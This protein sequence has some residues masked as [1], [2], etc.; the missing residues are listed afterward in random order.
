MSWY[1]LIPWPIA[2]LLGLLLLAL[3][4]W[5]LVADPPRRW[6]W[7]LRL[8]TALAMTI[9]LLG[10]AISGGSAREDATKVNVFFL[11]DTTTS[12]MARDHDGQRTRLEGY[13]E[14]IAKIRDE[15][16]GAR[17][18][19]ITF[20][21]AARVTM[22]LTTDLNALTS[23]TEGLRA[24]DHHYSGGSSVTLAGERLALALAGAKERTPER[25]RIVFYLGDGEQTASQEPAPF[26][27]GDLVDGGAV[28]GYGS[29]EGG[30]MTATRADGSP[31][32]EVEDAQ[33][34]PGM[35][36]IDEERLRGIAQQIGVPYIHRAGGDIAPALTAAE[37]GTLEDG[38]GA[39]IETHTSLVWILALLMSALLCVDLFVTTRD[40][41]RLS[42]KNA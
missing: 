19:I 22:P 15:M 6:R 12:A 14:D 21:Y 40:A 24:E 2:V 37:P 29:P 17:F 31:G 38:A 26:E 5:R 18:S 35:S 28:L 1:P 36:T 39:E 33:G 23:A 9:A 27:L 30:R 34:N 25:P 42:R 13:Q 11:V 7:G 4:A 32:E 20:D 3:T 8:A 16:P 10:P 41:A